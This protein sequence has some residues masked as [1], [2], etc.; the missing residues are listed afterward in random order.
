MRDQVRCTAKP[1]KA[2]RLLQEIDIVLKDVTHILH[3]GDVGHKHSDPNG[4]KY[5]YHRW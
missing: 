4:E 2:E 5:T 3:A 1:F